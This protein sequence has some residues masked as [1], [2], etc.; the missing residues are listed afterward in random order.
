M[1]VEIWHQAALI[2]ALLPPLSRH[3]TP[4]L[5]ES[6]NCNKWNGTINGFCETTI[7]RALCRI[8]RTATML[9]F[10]EKTCYREG[11][12]VSSIK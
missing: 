9:M 2:P 4:T 5:G 6:V 10:N 12:T 3:P 1:R 11:I 7:S 8:L